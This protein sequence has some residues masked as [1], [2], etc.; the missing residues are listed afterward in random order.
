MISSETN[1]LNLP[2]GYAVFILQNIRMWD[3]IQLDGWGCFPLY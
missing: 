2:E 1:K 3:N